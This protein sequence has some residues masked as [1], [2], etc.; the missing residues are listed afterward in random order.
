MRCF[1]LLAPLA[2][3]SLVQIPDPIPTES[4][5]IDM[6][7]ASLT[8]YAFPAN[9][10]SFV[11][12][13]IPDNR[14]LEATGKAAGRV[15]PPAIIAISVAGALLVAGASFL[16]FRRRKQAKEEREVDAVAVYNQFWKEKTACLAKSSSTLTQI[17]EFRIVE[18]VAGKEF[19][20]RSMGEE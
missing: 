4:L 11:T 14:I 16:F 9:A 3:G 8:A 12:A 7:Y 13:G 19:E 10:T 20:I 1:F 2:R 5:V 17:H 6:Q 18:V 15:Q